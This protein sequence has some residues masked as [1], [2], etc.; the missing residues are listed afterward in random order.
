MEIYVKI[1]LVSYLRR[2]DFKMPTQ[3]ITPSFPLVINEDTGN[4]EAYGI[5]DL[6]KVVDQNIK[7]T[8]LTVPGERMMDQNFG[9][10]LS[11]YLFENDTTIKRGASNLP[12]LRENILSQLSTYVS[13]ITIQDLQ[14]DLVGDSNLMNIKIKYFVNDSNTASLFDL[15]IGE[16]NNSLP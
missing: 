2:E 9:V 15:T 6:T 10:G 7:M 1:I 16:V 13:Y 14:I 3:T 5:A 12:P 11:R 4:Y 8:L